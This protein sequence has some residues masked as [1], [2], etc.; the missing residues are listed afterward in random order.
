MQYTVLAE[1]EE[2]GG[3]RVWCPALKGCYS[4]EETQE[5]AL[6]NIQE[7]IAACL[8]SLQDDGLPLPADVTIRHVEAE[9]SYIRIG[10]DIHGTTNDA[11]RVSEF[12]HDRQG[13]C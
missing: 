11:E 13:A 3:F 2:E 5:E 4:Q 9:V 6:E 1:T 7:A 10:M 8:E 12:H